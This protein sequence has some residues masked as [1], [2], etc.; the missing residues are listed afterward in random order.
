MR[1]EDIRVVEGKSTLEWLAHA[2]QYAASNGVALRL[3]V[4]AD[5]VKWDAGNTGWTPSVGRVADTC[6]R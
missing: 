6:G 5:G 4:S 1:P 3:Y 2:A